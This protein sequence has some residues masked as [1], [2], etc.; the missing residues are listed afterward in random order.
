M[1]DIVSVSKRKDTKNGSKHF[2]DT[3]WSRPGDA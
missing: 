2:G 1:L 3:D